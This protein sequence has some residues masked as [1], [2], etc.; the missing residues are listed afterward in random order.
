[1]NGARAYRFVTEMNR[2]V[3]R[4]LYRSPVSI[5]IDLLNNIVCDG[6]INDSIVYF[7]LNYYP[8]SNGNFER[9]KE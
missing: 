7:L 9:Y 3:M 1:M 4:V 6:A 2:F 8:I 5:A